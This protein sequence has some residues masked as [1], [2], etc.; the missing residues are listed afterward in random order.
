MAVRAEEPQVL[1]SIVPAVTIDV[2]QFQRHRLPS[3]FRA[4][5]PVA[6][7][8]EHTFTKKSLRQALRVL[9]L[10]VLDQNGVQR[11]PGG[12]VQ[13][14][15]TTQVARA[16][17]VGRV[18]FQSPYVLVECLVVVSPSLHVQPFERFANGLRF[19]DGRTKVIVGPARP[20]PTRNMQPERGSPR[21]DGL[22]VLYAERAQNVRN[23]PRLG[24]GGYELLVG[25]G[26]GHSGKSSG[27]AEGRG[28]E[29]RRPF[30]RLISSQLPYH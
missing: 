13:P 19:R 1:A 20:F 30:G 25:P 6:P 3:P 28:L 4:F 21:H 18:D 23:A 27:E 8:L 29:P 7:P 15:L 14:R 2:V 26:A 9:V 17:E 12:K 22:A 11:P 10:A 5:A 24:D 16:V